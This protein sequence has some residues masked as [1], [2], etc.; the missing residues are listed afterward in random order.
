MVL[1]TLAAKVRVGT[2][3]NRREDCLRG[4][5]GNLL[6]DRS[7]GNLAVTN[8]VQNDSIVA[9]CAVRMEGELQRVAMDT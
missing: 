3:T 9:G 4:V 2:R 1:G 7:G 5:M 8:E 6:L